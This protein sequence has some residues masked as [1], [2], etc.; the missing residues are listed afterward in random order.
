MLDP[1][2]ISNLIENNKNNQHGL[3]LFWVVKAASLNTVGYCEKSARFLRWCF[4]CRVC[5]YFK[6]IYGYYEHH[7]YQHRTNCQ[8][9]KDAYGKRKV[10]KFVA[11]CSGFKLIFICSFNHS[12]CISS[13]F[14]SYLLEE[15]VFELH[16][17]SIGNRSQIK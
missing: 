1:L 17:W 5:V 16:E 13:I 8:W 15:K 9:K 6:W 3:A 7:K 11:M 14:D 12:K 4:S 10:G 2:F